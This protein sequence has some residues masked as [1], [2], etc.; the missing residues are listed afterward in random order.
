MKNLDRLSSVFFIL[1]SI[2]I[3]LESLKLP[4]ASLSNPGPL[5]FPFL[6]GLSLLILSIVLFVQS[7]YSPLSNFS[8]LF[9]KGELFKAIYVLG[10]FSLSI[11]IFEPMGFVVSMFVLMVLLLKGIGG[12]TVVMSIFFAL[13]ITLPT[14]FLFTLLGVR[15]PQGVLWF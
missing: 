10:I 3:C 7:V 6:L 1:L 14:Y 9:Q 12:K 2:A 13:I 8:E 5:I 11:I 4:E 15:L